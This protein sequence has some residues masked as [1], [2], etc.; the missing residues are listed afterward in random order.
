VGNITSITSGVNPGEKVVTDGQDKLQPGSK[1]EV[2]N[3]GGQAP[4]QPQSGQ[5]MQAPGQ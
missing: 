5:G 1:V 3:G 2:R 4:A